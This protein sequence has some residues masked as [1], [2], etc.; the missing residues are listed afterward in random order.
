MNVVFF[1]CSF[2]SNNMFADRLI[3]RRS[4][5]GQIW[6]KISC[7]IHLHSIHYRLDFNVFCHR[8]SIDL[9]GT[10]NSRNWCW[11]VQLHYWYR[12]LFL[13]FYARSHS[14]QNAIAN[15]VCII[16]FQS[17]V[18][19]FLFILGLTTVSLIYVSEISHPK[20]RPMLLGLNSVFVS[21][22][23]LLTSV[24]GQFF[25]WHTMSAIFIGGTI[26]TCFLM[27]CIPESPYWLATFQKNRND[28]IETSL[29]WI[30]KSSEVLV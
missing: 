2:F 28:D 27:L 30:Y 26:F 23:I 10:N 5:N 22:G 6:T 4:V 20:L 17:N 29:R 25:N 21:F 9:C 1:S 3:Y 12:E 15:G 18:L 19:F 14:G 24:L 8:C 16:Q 11:F 13:V 7:F